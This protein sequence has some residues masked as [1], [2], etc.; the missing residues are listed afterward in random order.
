MILK[1][2]IVNADVGTYVDVKFIPLDIL[3]TVDIVTYFSCWK[4]FAILL[5]RNLV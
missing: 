3:I 2:I 4:L 5:K 1:I